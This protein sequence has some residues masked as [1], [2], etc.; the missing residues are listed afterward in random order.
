MSDTNSDS[1]TNAANQTASTSPFV[2]FDNES[3][4]AT[5]GGDGFAVATVSEWAFAA[6]ETRGSG[7]AIDALRGPQEAEVPPIIAAP[8]IAA[9]TMMILAEADMFVEQGDALVAMA[10]AAAESASQSAAADEA[11]PA[12]WS[13]DEAAIG[14]G[15]AIEFGGGE[16]ML[17][18]GDIAPHGFSLDWTDLGPLSL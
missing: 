16:R 4:T 8:V 13:G 1:Q 3:T 10:P 18:A 2:S 17:A 12:M 11:T 5:D 9:A 6:I 7:D 14:A 15:H